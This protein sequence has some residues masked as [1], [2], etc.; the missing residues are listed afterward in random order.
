L[1]EHT[2]LFSATLSIAGYRRG[3]IIDFEALHATIPANAP[4]N[5]HRAQQP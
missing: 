4:L 1:S 2:S 3:P 5:L